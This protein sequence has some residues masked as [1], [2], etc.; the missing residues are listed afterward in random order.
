MRTFAA[1][2]VC[3]LFVSCQAPPTEMTEAQ[4]EAI[5]AEIDSL[6]AEW[7]EAWETFDWDRGLSFIA[8]EPE[9][10]WTGAVRTLYSVHEMRE[11]WSEA[12]AGLQ[13]QELD[14]TNSR[15]VVLA[16]D[17]VWTLREGD[18]RIIDTTGA[19]VSEGQFIETAVWVK[20]DGEWKILLGHDDDSTPVT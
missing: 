14:F 3:S 5:V 20:R 17:I 19:V 13:R 2:A 7:W 8:D 6:T 16:P 4:R 15:T 18:S 11:V 12:M 10:T 1:F 9:T